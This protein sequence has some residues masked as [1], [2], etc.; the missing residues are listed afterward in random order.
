M[1]SLSTSS[2]CSAVETMCL[3]VLCTVLIPVL[4]FSS[5]ITRASEGSHDQLL[6][7]KLVKYNSEVF[8][9]ICAHYSIV[10]NRQLAV[11]R[12]M[13]QHMDHLVSSIFNNNY[14]RRWKT[15]SPFF[16]FIPCRF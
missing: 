5:V 15:L 16:S 12:E 13:Y 7:K 14:T 4:L 6:R 1:L 11:C 3:H 9:I 8:N 2:D 10:K